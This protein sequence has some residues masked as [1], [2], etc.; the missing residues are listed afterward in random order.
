M[1]I[2]LLWGEKA[3]E[4]KGEV[5]DAWQSECTRNYTALAWQGKALSNR[6][7]FLKQTISTDGELK[8]SSELYKNDYKEIILTSEEL[9]ISSRKKISLFE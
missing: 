1:T 9:E 8:K 7:R 4:A 5:S 3:E 2:I 6:K